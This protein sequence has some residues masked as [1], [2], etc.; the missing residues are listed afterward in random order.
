MNRSLDMKGWIL[1][2]V[3]TLVLACTSGP[4][5]IPEDQRS[6]F[7]T[8]VYELDT[9]QMER[10]MQQLLTADSSRLEA[11]SAVR[12]RYAAIGDYRDAPLWF[13]REGVSPEADSLLAFLRREV[14]AAGL[15]SV[16]FLLPQIA[17]D[18]YVVHRLAF[19]SVG[20][21]I[22][23]LL[24]RLDY[25]LS[26]AY[27]SYATGQRYG[28]IRPDELFNHLQKKAD[29]D[30]FARLFDYDVKSPDYAEALRQLS[31]GSR[32]GYLYDSQPSDPVYKVLQRRLLAGGCSQDERSRL[33]ASM[34]RC[35]WQILRP[36]VGE[37]HVFV[38][39][40]AQQLW[41]CAPDSAL[42]MKICCGANATR[43]PLLASSISYMQVNPEW[44][45][46]PSIVRGEVARHGGDSA[47]FARNRYF[48]VERTSGD[49]LSPASVT[50]AR[51]S[52][53][54]LRVAQKGGAGNSLGRI[55]FRFPN[56][57]AVYL[58]DTNNHG[59]FQRERRTLSHGCVRVE[60]PFEL[61]CFLLP[62][63]DEWLLDRICISMDRK[64][65][66]AR[67]L[68]YLA[69]HAD[70]PR[71]LRL[72]DYQKVSPSVPVYI[73]YYT[74]YPNPST[75]IVEFHPDVYGYDQV[76]LSALSVGL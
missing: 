58:H 73:A 43:T 4:Q 33:R 37:R 52:S 76:I 36:T 72:I 45:I 5:E 34:E 14:P 61:A 8:Y 35:R 20:V 22:N 56:D 1:V 31:S 2:V 68:D 54:Q 65:M 21:S 32:M 25:R 47:Y 16:C 62:D 9:L 40:P 28:F 57:F 46:P 29:A 39:I 17:A 50:P 41:A 64:P 67:G 19:D 26:C 6:A 59:A 13:T 7:G 24:P 38:N 23:E 18:L 51:L 69:E 71:P 15:D 10:Q 70:D 74:A 12:D 60:K 63:A 66:T 53:G 3:T 75:G 44:V 11:S 27:V 30:V 42:N 49:T 48:I 55:V